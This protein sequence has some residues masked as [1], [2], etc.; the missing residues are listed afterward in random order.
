MNCNVSFYTVSEM[1]KDKRNDKMLY[2]V[3]SCLISTSFMNDVDSDIEEID[4]NM[5]ILMMCISL[6]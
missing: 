2:Q 5:M 3:P 1:I 6:K 4:I